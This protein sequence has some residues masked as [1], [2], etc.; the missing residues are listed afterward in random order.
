ME[1]ELLLMLPGPVP[2]P[3][4]VRLAM[5][6][7][8][9][10]HRSPEFGAVYADCVRCLKPAFGTEHDLV[11]IS[12]S[13]TAGMEA[14]IANV[15]RDKEIACLVEREV[16]R[17]ACTTSEALRRRDPRSSRTGA[18]RSR[19]RRSPRASRPAPRS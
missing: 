12:G 7:Q 10:N 1:K 18:R 13:G 3:E 2:V 6:R 8:A 5:A 9:I 15:G 17:A 16:R 11:I 19:S 4:R 14:A